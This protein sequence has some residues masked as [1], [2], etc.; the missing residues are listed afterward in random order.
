[1]KTALTNFAIDV[2]EGGVAGAC[3][4]LA[5]TNLDVANPKVLAIALLS[6]ALT[7][8]IAAARRYAVTKTA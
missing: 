7:G 8:A 2:F 4:V 3:A 6:G 1:M 5:A